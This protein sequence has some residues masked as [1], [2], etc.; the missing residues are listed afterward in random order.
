MTTGYHSRLSNE[1]QHLLVSY[2]GTM[3]FTSSNYDG[4]R[5]G[6]GNENEAGKKI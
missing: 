1:R 2:A 6:H 5:D 3:S 4:D